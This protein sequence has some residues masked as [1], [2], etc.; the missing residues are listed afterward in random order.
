MNMVRI[1][2]HV[3]S[4]SPA[5]V[6]TPRLFARTEGSEGSWIYC[7]GPNQVEVLQNVSMLLKEVVRDAF[8][9]GQEGNEQI[10]LCIQQMT[11]EEV[12]DIPEM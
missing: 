2:L 3:M 7:G 4:S 1:K 6:K 9:E 12:S 8:S 5:G 10:E 11:E